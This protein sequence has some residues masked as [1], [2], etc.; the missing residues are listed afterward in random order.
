[1][2]YDG[3]GARN[4]RALPTLESEPHRHHDVRVLRVLG[5]PDYPRSDL[6]RQ[7]QF[8][9]ISLTVHLQDVDQIP[10]VE[11]DGQGLSAER[12]L[13]VLARLALIGIARRQLE[14]ALLQVE[15]HTARPLARQQR[16]AP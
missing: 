7:P 16:D 13:D 10:G 8:H 2:R 14:A 3:S 12:D 11:A 4:S 1:M 9:H 15:L 5:P 6:V